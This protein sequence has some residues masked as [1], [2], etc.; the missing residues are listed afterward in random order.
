MPEMPF[1]DWAADALPDGRTIALDD[2]ELE[3]ISGPIQDATAPAP[4][5]A[6]LIQQVGR[7]RLVYRTYFHD[8]DQL[9]LHPRSR[10]RVDGLLRQR[11]NL[12]I[13]PRGGQPRC[14]PVRGVVRAYPG[15]EAHRCLVIDPD[16]QPTPRH[17]DPFAKLKRIITE[18]A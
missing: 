6:E 15:D 2:A 11:G 8:F 5:Y 3:F 10:S 17:D 14:A 7:R 12:F 4:Y 9:G 18:S 1:D 13:D 16:H